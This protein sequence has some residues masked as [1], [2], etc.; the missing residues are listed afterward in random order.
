M[1][2]RW[3]ALATVGIIV[4]LF[5]LPYPRILP[6]RAWTIMFLLAVTYGASLSFSPRLP[7]LRRLGTAY[8]AL[9][10][11]TYLW[12]GMWG[13]FPN[14]DLIE[15]ATWNDLISPYLLFSFFEQ[16]NHHYPYP[17]SKTA[18][19][20]LPQDQHL[21][22]SLTVIAVSIIAVIAAF[23]MAKSYK[24]A[25]RVWAVLLGLSIVSLTGYVIVALVSWGQDGLV[26]QSCWVASYIIAF[27]LACGG[28][29]LRPTGC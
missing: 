27:V 13:I 9:V 28:A 7:I 25:Y 4:I 8:L 21:V 29:G 23:A 24:T 6:N 12:A 5:W 3:K 26:I 19:Y 11:L 1:R 15:A 20:F 22:F 18:F 10:G 17:A 14:G 16:M 2:R